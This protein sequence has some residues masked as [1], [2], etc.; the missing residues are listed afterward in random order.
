MPTYNRAAYIGESVE[1][2]LSQTYSNWELIIVDDASEDNTEE[3]ISQI[4]DNRIKYHKTPKT[5]VGIR[6]RNI[7]IEKTE[8]ELIAFIDSD[9]LWAPTKLEKQVTALHDHP[10]AAFSVTNGYNFKK[11]N[12]PRDYFYKEREG[13][14][15][16]DIL[17]SIFKSE[18][19]V[20]PQSLMF[21]KQCLPVI[22]RFVETA[23]ASDVEFMIGLAAEFKAVILYEP[24]LYRRIHDDNFTAAYWER[25]YQEG[26]KMINVY[27]NNGCLSVKDAAD[28]FFR[29][30]INFGESYL[31]RKKKKRAIQNF[32]KAWRYKLFSLQP[33]RKIA[34]TVLR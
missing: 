20:M 22:Q 30:Y 6:L 11:K 23:P 27:K 1:S 19:S 12:E 14:R 15:Y 4:N 24:L 2:I 17:L 29:L 28:A 26:I 13:V 18:A 3:I 32:F 25:G 16:D 10:D 33:I 8:G 31:L 34:K 5:G 9:D 7:G 21:R